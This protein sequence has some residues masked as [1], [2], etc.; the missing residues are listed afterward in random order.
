[1]L[2]LIAYFNNFTIL[3]LIGRHIPQA[4]FLKE[5]LKLNKITI[6]QVIAE[7]IEQKKSQLLDFYNILMEVNEEE[8]NLEGMQPTKKVKIDPTFY[9][10]DRKIIVFAKFDEQSSLNLTLTDIT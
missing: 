2:I 5:L 4:H 9:L 8:G 7:S 6:F 3:I 1:M 10:I